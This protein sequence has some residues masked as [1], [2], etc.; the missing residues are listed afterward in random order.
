TT[1]GSTSAPPAW[2]FARRTASWRLDELEG[3][4]EAMRTPGYPLFL[5]A[6]R[7]IGLTPIQVTLVQLLLRVAMIG[8]FIRFAGT[9]GASFCARLLTAAWLA[10]DQWGLWCANKIVT[11]TLF[12]IVLFA[13]V[14]LAAD[15]LRAHRI[16][17]AR[18]VLLGLL[19]GAATLVRPV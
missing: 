8:L 17:A 12:T 18:A 14:W 4:V 3:E 16:T 7:H 15:S 19:I 6:M 13:I 9:P 2:R 1:R 10:F 11:E 5:A